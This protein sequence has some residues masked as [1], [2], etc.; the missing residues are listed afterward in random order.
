MT[1]NQEYNKLLSSGE[2]FELFPEL[3]G[4]WE[5]DRS[6]FERDWEMNQ[7]IF[8]MDVVI[9]LDDVDEIENYD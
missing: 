9:D 1:A 7:E 5:K 2:L 6:R 8:N 4:D 3:S